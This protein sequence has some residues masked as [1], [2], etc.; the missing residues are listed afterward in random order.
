[1]LETL[2]WGDSTKR[3]FGIYHAPQFGPRRDS[4]IVLCYPMMR[5]YIR[6]HRAY[7]QLAVRL[8]DVGFPVLRFDYYGCGDSYGESGEGGVQQWLRE[9]SSAIGEIRRKSNL[10]DVCLIGLRFGATLGMMAGAERGDIEDMVLWDPIVDGSAYLDEMAAL[11]QD[12][13]SFPQKKSIQDLIEEGDGVLG[14]PFT[15]SMLSELEEINL[16]AIRQK[17]ANSLLILE[18]HEHGGEGS[19]SI[20]EHLVFFAKLAQA[21]SYRSSHREPRF[22][23]EKLH[24]SLRVF[25]FRLNRQALPCILKTGEPAGRQG[26][27]GGYYELR[28]LLDGFDQF[29]RGGGLCHGSSCRIH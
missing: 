1:M 26:G 28:S 10:T 22:S 11:H 21:Q 8:S 2:Y 19:R 20:R 14:F 18:S 6:S 16:L 12:L 15:D 4:G 9:I 13:A 7:R 17:P 3:L 5:E 29:L 27:P 25:M 24:F 23:P